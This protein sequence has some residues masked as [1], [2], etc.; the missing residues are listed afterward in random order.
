MS[1]KYPKEFKLSRF[2]LKRSSVQI[3]STL[4]ATWALLFWPT[5]LTAIDWTLLLDERSF[6]LL[7]FIQVKF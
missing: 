4:R 1:Y 2:H 7:Y 6:R 5:W 3:A